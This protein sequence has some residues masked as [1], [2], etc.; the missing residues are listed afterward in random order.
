MKNNDSIESC[1][2]RVY[3]VA[4][5]LLDK[6]VRYFSVA[7]R[8]GIFVLQPLFDAV[9]MKD[10]LHIARQR[11]NII[12]LRKL[13]HTNDTV[14]GRVFVAVDQSAKLLHSQPGQHIVIGCFPVRSLVPSPQVAEKGHTDAYCCGVE[15]ALAHG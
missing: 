9:L 8:A 10:V 7:K 15:A 11:R 5:L 12:L 6:L 14:L 4:T 1:Y 3:V 2:S 13:R